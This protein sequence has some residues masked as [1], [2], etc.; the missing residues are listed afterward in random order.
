MGYHVRLCRSLIGGCAVF[1]IAATFLAAQATSPPSSR[2]LFKNHHLLLALAAARSEKDVLLILASRP[3]ANAKTA[4]EVVKLGGAVH[5]RED[6]VDY[7]RARVPVD[8]VARLAQS[9]NVQ[10]L[11]IDVDADKWDPGWDNLF[12]PEKEEPSNIPPDPDTPLSHPYLPTHDMDIDRF[13]AD[14]PTFDG[15]GVGMAIL[16]ATPDFLLP[17]LQTATTL[18]G[19]PQR[20]IAVAMSASDP[21]DDDDPMWVKMDT[22]VQAQGGQFRYHDE[23]Y[24]TPGDGEY[25]LGFFNERALHAPGYLYQDVNFDGNP[26]GS[27][28]L[29][30]VLWDDKKNVVWVDTNQDKSF[31]DEKAMMD[32]AR[33]MDIGIFGSNVP[34]GKRRKSVAFVVQT[35]PE[36]KY[37]RITLGVWQ[38]VTEVA[39]AS[40]GKGFYGGSYGG[41]A[42]EAQFISIFSSSSIYRIVESA[43]IAAK[44]E[45]VDVICVEPS[46]L[47]ATINPLHDGHLVA[48]VV[49]DR[50]IDKYR[51]PIFSPANNEPGV[52]T[53]VDEVSAN[54]LVAVGAYQSGEAYR[55][56]NGA[57]VTNHDNLHL[58]GSFGPA[59]DGGLKPEII[60]ASELISTDAGYKP[61]EKRKGVYEL[62]SGYSV[63]GGTSTAGPTATAAA[64][65]L[66]S[67]AKQTGI[68]YDAERIRTALLSSARFIPHIPAYKQGN[69]LVQVE[70]AWLLLKEMDKKFAPV[71]ITSRAPVR[72]AVSQ[73]L[74]P[75][76]QGRGIY[77][78]EGWSPGQSGSRTITFTRRSGGPQPMTF[79]LEWVGNDGTFRSAETITLPLNTP[80]E[81][82]VGVDVKGAGVHSAILNLKR[83]G[84]PWIVH[85]VMNT[86]V[87]AEDF[88]DGGQ[89]R[90]ERRF[91]VERPGTASLFLRVP[92][93]TPALHLDVAIPDGKPTLR[94]SAIAPDLN[95]R[96][97]F[98]VVGMTDK[99]HLGKTIRQPVPGVWEFVFFGNNFVFSPEQIDSKPLAP[100]P[101]S[102]IATLI[103]VE[104]SEPQCR[105]DKSALQGCPTEV[106]FSNRLGAF[107]GV[108]RTASLG[109][110]RRLEESILE[111]QQKV[112]EIDVPPGTEKISARVSDVSDENAEL[113]LYLFQEVKGIAALR[114]SNTGRGAVKSVDVN[115][116]APGRWKVVV[117]GYALPSGSAHF[118]YTDL[119][120][121]P[122]LGTIEVDCTPALIKSGAQWKV[123][124]KVSLR[125]IPA[126]DRALVGLIPVYAVEEAETSEAKNEF[127]KRLKEANFSVGMATFDFK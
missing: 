24:T 52:N 11:D 102:V 2:K 32:Y 85:Q 23:T 31:A 78:R 5:F 86:I 106:T 54:K 33:R 14:G 117:D 83:P 63:A 26:A 90:L 92:P 113:D 7:L 127:E 111:N 104:A 22:V 81:L 123:T 42:P 47:E 55:I 4:E 12:P 82:V 110:S 27:S 20:K 70:A 50:I 97:E 10:S 93:N 44:S 87:A 114:D 16:D 69:G 40:L 94:V 30:A 58:V 120:T 1:A 8:G 74:D 98:G 122:A 77:E 34:A 75:P 51:K 17:E 25:R 108:A 99:G 18:D 91:S 13:I 46:I 56:N 19:R 64:A 29:F 89:Y 65:L 21:L 73:W 115:S 49:F 126:G 105:L 88:T 15:R 6:S 39:G 41:V 72:T 119:M 57:V 28:G 71:E 100:V 37:V 125:A 112:Y 76:N 61:P 118:K 107:R 80:V 43:I 66:V 36:K 124:P 103:G 116:P 67:A 38:H 3:G 79:R 84:F 121:H 95:P 109:S 101:T 62:P 68:A 60:S 45:K 48:G 35:D 53:V 9:S 96:L 59:G